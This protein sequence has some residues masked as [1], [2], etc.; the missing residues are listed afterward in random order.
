[1]VD[2]AI[3]LDFVQKYG[4]IIFTILVILIAM[5]IF[6][7][8]SSAAQGSTIFLLGECFSGKTTLLYY[9]IKCD[10]IIFYFFVA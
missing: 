4:V 7:K 10:E 1:M 3:I 5:K 6:R 9:V 8:K 2:L